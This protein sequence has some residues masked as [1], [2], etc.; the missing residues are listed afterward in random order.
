MAS[1]GPRKANGG[2]D[3]SQSP[4]HLL[5][6]CVQYAN[7]LFSRE[8]G[9]SD[10][11][12]QQFTVLAAVE[13]NEGMSQ[14]DLVAITGIDRSTLAEMIRRMIDKGLLDRERTEADQRANAVRIAMAG[15]K[16][17]RGARSASDRVE[18]AL[19]A[20]LNAADRARFLKMLSTVV[21]QAEGEDGSGGE[22]R[23]KA[24]RR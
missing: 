16:A 6:R 18:R 8:P 14:T 17:L 5:R 3:L 10:L 15:K 23:A 7:D 24:R 21:S 4:S 12:K 22:P 9:A 11:T 1:K 2:F 20:G 19:L 13:Q